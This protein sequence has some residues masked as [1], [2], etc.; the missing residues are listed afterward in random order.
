[1]NTYRLFRH[2]GVR[3]TVMDMNDEDMEW[4]LNSLRLMQEH[5]QELAGEHKDHVI[6]ASD[7]GEGSTTPDAE[8]HVGDMFLEQ[9]G[10]V[11][12]LRERIVTLVG[13]D[14]TDG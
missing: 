9:H 7:I 8:A 2:D 10:D 12:S 3:E 14:L 4:V 13:R 11:T 6:R 5:Q 1:V